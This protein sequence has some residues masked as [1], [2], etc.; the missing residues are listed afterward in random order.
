MKK[1]TSGLITTTKV[2]TVIGAIFTSILSYGIALVW[3]I[4]MTVSYFNR[5]NEGRSIGIGFKIC[6]MLLVGQLAGILML[7]DNE[8]D[9]KNKNVNKGYRSNTGYHQNEGDVKTPAETDTQVTVPSWIKIGNKIEHKN[10]GI[11]TIADV[12]DEFITIKK[13]EEEIK[14]NLGY[15]L[16]NGLITQIKNDIL[17]PSDYSPLPS[18]D[19]L[20]PPLFVTVGNR[21]LH[22]T[23]GEVKIISL[24]EEYVFVQD[25][26]EKV[27]FLKKEK[28]H[29][30]LAPLP[31]FKAGTTIIHKELGKVWVTKVTESTITVIDKNG[32]PYCLNLDYC[33]EHNLLNENND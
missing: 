5:I 18:K 29:D 9:L 20:L 31:A 19:V 11:V 10:F 17:P 2:F 8:N 33:T 6:T 30:L 15:V 27:F 16:N 4:P 26:N 13:D 21:V 24:S 12:G 3:C 22:K 7:C 14:L 23:C 25:L 1:R 28:A 32:T